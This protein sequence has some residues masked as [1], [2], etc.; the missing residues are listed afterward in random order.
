VYD[1]P[2]DDALAATADTSNHGCSA[3]RDTNL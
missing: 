1:L 3:S 2:A